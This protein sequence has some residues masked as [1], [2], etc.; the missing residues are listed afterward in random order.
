MNPKQTLL[1]DAQVRVAL[2]DSEQRLQSVVNSA[3]MVLW[4]I[5]GDGIFTFSAGRGLELLGLEAGEIVGQ[6]LFELYADVPQILEDARRALAGEEFTSTIDLGNLVFES[7]YTPT[8]DESGEVTGVIGIA[9]DITD[10]RRS[11]LENSQNLSLLRATLESTAD[12]ILVVDAQGRIEGYNLKFA[13]MWDIPPEVLE[14][15]RDELAIAHVL[16]LLEDPEAFGRRISDLYA[17]PDAESFDVLRFKDGRVYERYSQPQRLGETIIGRVWSFRDVTERYRAEEELRRREQQLEHAEA[18]YRAL[19]DLSNDAICVHD[20]ETGAILDANRKAYELYGCVPG[21][22]TGLTQAAAAAS[23][24]RGGH[25]PKDAIARAAAGESQRFEFQVKRRLGGPVWVEVRLRRVAINGVDRLLATLRDVT[26]RKAAEAVLERS[27]DELD[28]LVR[29]RTAELAHTNSVLETEIADRQRAES[30]LHRRTTELEAIA[31]ALPDLYLRLDDTGLILS[32]RSGQDATLGLVENAYVGVPFLDL[33]PKDA[34]AEMARGLEEVAT[35]GT[36]VRIEYSL[37]FD[38]GDRWFEVRVLPM[39]EG[40]VLAVIRDITQRKRAESALR[41]SEERYRLLVENSSD[42]ASILDMNGI[43]RYQSPAVRYVLGYTPEEMVGTSSMDRIHPDDVPACRE[44]LGWVLSNPGQTRAVEFRYRHKDG[45]WR[46]LEARA[47]TLLPDS[48]AEGAIVNSRDV[49]DRKRYETALEQAKEEAESANRAKSEFLSRMS[50]ELRT[51]MNSI[52]GFGQLLE[53]KD[54]PQ[55]QRK[56]VDH[57]LRA[58]RHLLNLINEVLEISRIESGRQHVS[59]EPVPVAAVLR[60]ARSL[61]LPLANQRSLTIGECVIADDIYVHADRQRLVQVL[62]NLLSNSVKYNRPEGSVTLVCE[63]VVGADGTAVVRLGVGDTGPGIPEEKLDRLFIPFERLGA[64]HS[65]VEGTGLGLALSLRLVEVMDG[66]LRVESEVGVGSTFWVELRRVDGPLEQA[67][68]AHRARVDAS[69][70]PVSPTAARI[71]YIEDNLPN[72]TLIETILADRPNL[73]LLTA[74]QGQM[75][76][77]LAV[78]HRPDLIL[79]DMHLPDINGDEVLRRLQADARTR[80]T[81]VIVVSADATSS[82][83]EKLLTAGAAGYLTKPLD[84][85]EF[86]ATVDRY[87]AG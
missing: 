32:H 81:P 83:V 86:I 21:D 34:R 25:V 17:T 68:A 67:R 53:R 31:R 22:L 82:T 33:L 51:P 5:D 47:R 54:L 42:V 63:E 49:T 35:T 24:V 15:G 41:Q 87:V 71:L 79:L 62:L 2:R 85:A 73:T 69:P 75:G 64:E 77:Y 3:S 29:A 65:Q 38:D 12:G 61:I 36:L 55:D 57:I 10:W 48:A 56:A 78:E 13:E 6:N 18:S 27:R 72:L 58:G 44:A 66:N 9:V 50:H 59:L 20:L 40:E 70:D 74:V 43:N 84:V 46:I 19:F 39:T 23:S 7:R 30:E 76:V 11:E 60:E 45:S 1:S 80:D 16:S 52:L 4:A 26:E 8:R 14:E 37:P 28:A